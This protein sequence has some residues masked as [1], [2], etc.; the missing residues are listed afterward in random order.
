[1][2]ALKAD[3]TT[4]ALVLECKKTLLSLTRM[5]KV[6]LTWVPGHSG[7]RGNEEADRLAGLATIRKVLNPLDIQVTRPRRLCGFVR[8]TEL[9]GY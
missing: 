3:S 4:S 7:V 6:R 2:A 5:T 9:E 1:M 8:A